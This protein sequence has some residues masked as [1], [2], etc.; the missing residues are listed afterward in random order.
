VGY[1]TRVEA[2]IHSFRNHAARQGKAEPPLGSA[3]PG[4]G[5]APKLERRLDGKTLLFPN[6]DRLT[7]PLVVANL[8]SAGVDARVL[9]E[10][11]L[12]IQAGT[13]LNTGQCLPINA[14]TQGM[15]NYIQRHGLDPART[16]LWMADSVL[17]CNFRL[18]PHYIKSL[19][20]SY[21]EGMEQAGV[22]V[23]DLSH[24]EISPFLGVGA[25]FAYLFGGL[26]RR[27]GCRIRPYEIDSGQTDRTMD[28]AQG[29]L[30]DSF[31][32]NRSKEDALSQVIALFEA[33]PKQWGRRPKVAIFG[34]LYVRDNDV[35]NQDLIHFIE[36]AGGEVVTT[37]YS[38]YLRIIAD[39]VFKKWNRQHRYW[40][41]V[42]FRTL[43]A[44]VKL[45]ERRYFNYYEQ[46]VSSPSSYRNHRPERTLKLFNVRLEHQGESWDNLLKIQHIVEEY[47][48]VRLFVQTNPA[49]C[50]PSL[51]TEA[52]AG[53]IEEVTGVPVVTLTYDGTGSLKNDRIVP[54]LTGLAE[55]A[56]RSQ[57]PLAPSILRCSR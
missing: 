35:M 48:D 12:S 37:P 42:K 51:V 18:F 15:V 43:L 54:Y 9:E 3:R 1:E 32:G 38:E 27:L 14:I 39:A 4:S 28:A 24:S 41:L 40:A 19:L 31:L 46:Y 55:P 57:S 17:S 49:F 2:G 6:W 25:Y 8:R 5:F 10:D 56:N 21:G 50:C 44:L 34:D 29:I 26:L 13:R 30:V 7:I 11:E 36:Q 47:P 22:Y 20:E 16:V 33:I 23:G 52:M 45:L 53:R